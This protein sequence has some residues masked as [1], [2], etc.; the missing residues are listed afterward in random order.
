M[1]NEAGLPLT[2]EAYADIDTGDRLLAYSSRG[3]A[4]VSIIARH[5]MHR[6]HC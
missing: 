2:L 4:S 3:I 6:H 1:I 5:E